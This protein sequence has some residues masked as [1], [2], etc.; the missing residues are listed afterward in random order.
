MADDKEWLNLETATSPS[1]TVSPNQSADENQEVQMDYDVASPI[2]SSRSCCTRR[3]VILVV[4]ASLLAI[5]AVVAISL[6]VLLPSGK[7][8]LVGNNGSHGNHGGEHVHAPTPAGFYGGRPTTSPGPTASNAYEIADIIERNARYGGDEFKDKNSYQ[9][10]AKKWVLTQDFPIQDGSSMTMEQ[11]ALQLFALA[12]IYFSTFSVTSVW[13]DV[14]YGPDVKLPGW[15]S[16]RGW[17]GTGEDVCSNWHGLTCN[18]QG[19][20]LKIELDT[21]GLTGSFPPETALLHETLTT[22]DLYNNMVHNSGDKGNSFLGELTNLEHLYLGTTSFEYDGVPSALGKL[23]ALK[24]LDFSN[25]LYF[26]KLDGTTFANLSNLRY[27]A[28]DGNA[29][30][31]SIP[32]ELAQLPKLEYL[33][34]SFTFL[35]GGLDFVGSMQSIKEL[36]VDDNPNLKGT[37]PSSIGNLSTLASFSAGGCGLTGNIPAEI[38]GATNVIQMWLN[39]NDLAGEIP[40]EIADLVSLKILHVQNNELEGAMPSTICDIR[41]PFGNLEELGADCDDAI[42]CDEECCT[43]CGEECAESR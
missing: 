10:L 2:S 5:G 24:E 12:C 26:G 34:A 32:L 3:K 25:S 27:L 7:K 41:R 18:D 16:S 43:C 39:N 19:R 36:W 8:T 42:T 29:Y 13:T 23:T 37:I 15:Y 6:T 20:I 21:N 30:N 11:Q 14:H 38:G 22:I 31:S 9:S 17:M 4:L 33:Y 1:N 28:M 40:S 35:E